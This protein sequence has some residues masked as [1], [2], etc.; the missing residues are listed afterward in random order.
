MAPL[1]KSGDIRPIIQLSPMD[2][3]GMDYIGPINPPCAAT[4]DKYILII[5]DYFSWF[6]F[7][8]AVVEATMQSTMD[9]ILNYIVPICGWPRS[10]SSD[11]G[12]HFVGGEMQTMLRNFGVTHFAAAISHASSVGL[13]KQ[14]VQM[15]VGRLRLK[16]ID[17]QSAD[18]WGLLLRDAIL[19][20]NTRCIRVQ[21]FS[22][23]EILLG[24]NPVTSRLQSAGGAAEDWLKEGLD[25]NDALHPTPEDIMWHMT[26]RD[27]NGKTAVDR[28][29]RLQ[30]RQER[31]SQPTRGYRKPR[32]GDLVL[33][34]DLARD[35]QH[36]RKLDPRWTEGR[37]VDRLSN[38]GMSAYIRPLH[39]PP[40]RAKR[41]HIDDLRV[42]ITRNGDTRS[43]NAP[44]DSSVPSD[45]ATTSRIATITY[46][47]TAMGDSP[48]LFVGGQRA[49]DLTDLMSRFGGA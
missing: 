1:K 4:G 5:V 29:T 18:H 6:L 37:M 19:D 49:F 33:L 38:N 30:H 16:C 17:C 3:W 8:R 44:K 2:M 7:G 13:A 41:Y 24:Y 48:G 36:R 31:A 25:P 23:A 20:I 28:L 34:R 26:A 27:E 14:Y 47:R 10:I 15:T 43:A 40:S 32:P 9:T 22:P 12:S 21:G 42:Y 11:N 46:S 45:E 35:K 39:D